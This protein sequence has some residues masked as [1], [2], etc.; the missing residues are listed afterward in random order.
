MVPLHGIVCRTHQD[1]LAHQDQQGQLAAKAQLDRQAVKDQLDRQAVKDQQD[2]QAVK[3]QQDQLA[4]KARQ[5]QL[6]AKAFKVPQGQQAAKEF[7]GPQ[8]Q[9]VHWGQLVLKEFRAFRVFKEPQVQQAQ[10]LLVPQDRQDQLGQQF[11]QQLALQCQLALPGDHL[12]E[13]VVQIQL[14]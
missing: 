13:Q 2:Q 1:L 5:D 11:I 4:A 9:L 10:A 6:A 14:F 12:M 8:D 7:K 3:D